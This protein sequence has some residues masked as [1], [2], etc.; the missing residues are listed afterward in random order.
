MNGVALL[1]LCAVLAITGACAK[2]GGDK[3]KKG[4]SGSAAK[5]V[6]AGTHRSYSAN[7]TPGYTVASALKKQVLANYP[8]ATVG[9][10]FE[11]YRF[12]SGKEWKST[13][14]ANAKMYVDFTGWFDPAKLDSAATGNG[15][16]KRGLE[17]KFV[18]IPTGSFY[19]AMVSKLEVTADGRIVRSP[20]E[21][22]KSVLD[23]IYANRE[24]T[25]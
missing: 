8:K 7:Q 12:L 1:L 5:G 10:A 20:L 16:V 18:V 13:Q 25:L 14:G 4:S 2:S 17:V 24:I 11:A 23:S 15:I 3:Q 9:D 19:V 22:I 21:E 6:I